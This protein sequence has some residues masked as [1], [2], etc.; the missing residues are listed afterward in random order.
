MIG[1]IGSPVYTRRSALGFAA[2]STALGFPAM[3]HATPDSLVTFEERHG[4]LGSADMR[5]APQFFLGNPE[6][7]VRVEVAWSIQCQYT[8]LL[9]NDGLGDFVQ[10][11]RHRNDALIVFHHLSRTQKELASSELLLSLEPMY[12]GP[13]CLVALQFFAKKGYNPTKNHLAALIKK[14]DLPKDPTFDIRAARV[15]TLLLNVYLSK[16]EKVTETPSLFSNGKWEVG[17]APAV[18]EKI[19]EEAGYDS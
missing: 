10:K 4:D 17:A 2:S 15:S 6:A 5:Y 18:L 12:Y 8:R 1:S 19:L 7:K 13:L 9:Y 3:A 16:R 14:M 11:V